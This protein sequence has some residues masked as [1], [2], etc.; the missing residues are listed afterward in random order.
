MAI[1]ANAGIALATPYASGLTNSGTSIG[2]RLNEAADNVK[3]VY[4]LDTVTNDLGV[5]SAGFTNV[6]LVIA[7]SYKVIVSKTGDCT[8]QTNTPVVP[9]NFAR[10]VTVNRNPASPYFGRVYVANVT[11]GVKGDGIFVF[12][13]DLS[14]TF[15]QGAMP[16]TAGLDFVT[17][18]TTVI[19][20]RLTVGENDDRLY[21][22]DWSN[23]SGNLYVTDPDV[24][25]NGF[26][27][28]TLSAPGAAVR[29]VTTANNHGSVAAAAVTGIEGVDLTIYTVDEDLTTDRDVALT[30]MNS[31][32]QYPV[33]PGSL[34]TLLFDPTN[35]LATPVVA[36]VSQTMDLARGPNGYLYMAQ[37]RSVGN[38][39]AIY[40]VD[41]TVGV[42]TNTLQISRELLGPTATD[43]LRATGGVSV[44]PDGKWLA[45][46]NIENN[47][48][49]IVALTDGIPDLSRRVTFTGLG[50]GSGRGIAFDAA[51]NLYAIT[52]SDRLVGVTLG[53]NSTAITGSDGTFQLIT[54]PFVHVVASDASANET[55]PDPGVFTFARD[56]DL[57]NPL[58]V[59]FAISG[60]ATNGVDYATI[61]TSITFAPGDATTNITVTPIDDALS[62][63]NETVI[64]TLDCNPDFSLVAG[65][66]ATVTIIDNDPPLVTI[67]TTVS[68]MYERIPDD[69]VRFRVTRGGDI[70]NS[71]L[72]VNLDFTGTAANG[73]DYFPSTTVAS[74]NPG[75]EF[76][77]VT[78]NPVDDNEVEG[79]E[80]IVA[81]IVAD[82]AYI[83]GAAN[84]ATA[85]LADDDFGP[86]FVLWSDDFET[87]TSA[88]WVVRPGAQNGVAD[89]H[90]I[91]NYDYSLKSVPLPPGGTTT[92]GLIMTANK[93]DDTASAA[94]VNLYPVGQSFSGDYALRF[95]MYIEGVS[96]AGTTEHIIFGIN[97]SGSKTNWAI[98]GTTGTGF[99]AATPGDGDGIWFNIVEDSSGFPGGND[100][101]AFN[102]VNSP[103]TIL[104]SRTA[105]SMT[106]VLKA[107]P[108]RFAGTPASFLGLAR[109]VWVDVEVRQIGGV[110]SLLINNTPVFEFNNSTGFGSGSIMLGYNDAF[111]S[112]GGTAANSDPD[113]ALVAAGWV[114]YD[115][116]R[117]VRIGPP[118]I[119]NSQIVGGEIQI[120]FSDSSYGP[121]TLQ[122]S[123]VVTG[124]YTN[125]TATL[126]TNAPGS[127]RF[128]APYTAEPQRY[129]RIQR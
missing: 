15:G 112:I 116:V 17:G 48:L 125:I 74:M 80:T 20:F 78:V 66:S 6:P 70:A 16:R 124:G 75:E 1:G 72:Q 23:I 82:P 63:P 99:N 28:Q 51:N 33:G 107:P 121:F 58:T 35:K 128:T 42:L 98:R 43:E 91:F 12:N 3:I 5:V 90:A 127:Y 79:T 26:A 96:G 111:G 102:S 104:A 115:D 114:V 52:L 71:S 129:Y 68:N 40:V 95:R 31:L 21:I 37:Y 94:G 93:T 103:P 25:T 105:A 65:K 81:T 7:G 85:Y 54:P 44:S 9:F 8:I 118:R 45:V 11:N 100:Y 122:T 88:N 83:V 29:P 117:V 46:L 49:Q 109:Q 50:T 120:D 38:E 2:F 77:D 34:P 64:L 59:T 123:P 32:W 60:L 57:G 55:G 56:G 10:G 67:S 61:P 101:G 27:L 36:T 76:A 30:E 92:R 113:I 62:E 86:E 39:P 69:F 108:Y 4:L 47:A 53:L 106:Q 41:P 24:T 89:Y 119:N 110:V 87:D 84:S 14:D 13:S 22:C 19:P 73:V 126:G 18:D 97:H